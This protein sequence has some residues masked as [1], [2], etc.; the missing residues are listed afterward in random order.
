MISVFGKPDPRDANTH[1]ENPN[2]SP[3]NC[4]DGSKLG[5]SFSSS[6]DSQESDG[7]D[8][9]NIHETVSEAYETCKS[10]SGCLSAKSSDEE[11]EDFSAALQRIFSETAQMIVIPA[12]KGSREKYGL[13]ARKMR[14]SWAEDVYDPP[15]SIESHT[16]VGRKKHHHQKSNHKKTVRKG[17]KGSGHSPSSSSRGG[18][19]KKQSSRKQSSSRDK[20]HVSNNPDIYCGGI[21]LRANPTKVL[22][23]VAAEAI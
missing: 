7:D 5:P 3:T 8:T 14:V 9:G 2:L 23:S 10:V 1:F 13:S 15:P 17:Q 18:K 4:S 22:Y 19:D 11:D 6:E 16:R 20:F 21:F 12:M